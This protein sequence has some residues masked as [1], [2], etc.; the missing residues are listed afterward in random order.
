MTEPNTDNTYNLLEKFTI[1]LNDRAENGELDPIVG[2]D[3]EIR[4]LLQIL[5]RR[6]KNNPAAHRRTRRR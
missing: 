4:R 5:S 1:N 3:E 2:R 6:K